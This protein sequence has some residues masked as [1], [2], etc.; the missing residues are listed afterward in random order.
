MPTYLVSGLQKAEGI[1]IFDLQLMVALDIIEFNE[2]YRILE[3]E[4]SEDNADLFLRLWT[5][6]D[7][8]IH[9]SLPNVG[10]TSYTVDTLLG[11]C[12]AYKGADESGDPLILFV[13]RNIW[14]NV[15]FIK[16]FL[17]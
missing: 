5:W 9:V 6:R 16:R 2:R 7:L 3:V 10:F 17:L 11:S 13:R 1:T 4:L 15:Q 12:I 8:S 14:R